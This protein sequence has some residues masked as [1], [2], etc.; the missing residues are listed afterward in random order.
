MGRASKASRL[1]IFIISQS[2]NGVCVGGR[3]VLLPV[4]DALDA[5][6]SRS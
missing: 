5:F 2:Q 1:F 6:G 4:K 3:A